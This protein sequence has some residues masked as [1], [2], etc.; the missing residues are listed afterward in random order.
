[1]P[2]DSASLTDA[3]NIQESKLS[4]GTCSMPVK[5]ANIPEKRAHFSENGHHELQGQSAE[6][7]KPSDPGLSTPLLENGRTNIHGKKA[8]DLKDLAQRLLFSETK[9][10]SST[11]RHNHESKFQYETENCSTHKKTSEN[12]PKLKF[13]EDTLAIVLNGSKDYILFSPTRMAAAK[14]RSGF[15]QQ[16]PKHGN[17][18]VSILTPPPGLD[19]SSLCSSPTDAGR[20]I[21]HSAPLNTMKQEKSL[22]K[23][24]LHN[25]PRNV[26]YLL[27]RL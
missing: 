27:H 21:L 11:G 9:S 25:F 14:K 2:V 12:R 7:I 19:L 13:K 16:K 23:T 17:L 4:K 22:T 1:M 8:K 15:Q 5:T 3:G 6:N 20:V 26:W 24:N 10:S 18:S